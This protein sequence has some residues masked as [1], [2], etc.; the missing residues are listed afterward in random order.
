MKGPACNK[1]MTRARE[2][3][4]YSSG[5][6]PHVTLQ[7]VEVRRFPDCGEHEVVIPRMTELHEAIARAVV[8]KNAR[9]LYFT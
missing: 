1:P 8:T 7:G 5:G 4:S 3:Y 9:A 6:L 2:N